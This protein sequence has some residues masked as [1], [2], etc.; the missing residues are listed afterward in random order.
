MES[1]AFRKSG[2]LEVYVVY[3]GKQA[4]KVKLEVSVFDRKQQEFDYLVPNVYQ[5]FSLKKTHSTVIKTYRKRCAIDEH[6]QKFIAKLQCKFVVKLNFEDIVPASVLKTSIGTDLDKLLNSGASHDFMIS[7]TND[8]T[9]PVHKLILS[10]RS[11]VLCA[12]LSSDLVE[13]NKG[14]I[15]IHDFDAAVVKSFVRYLYT[16]RCPES[17]LHDHA[18]ALLQMADKYDVRGLSTKCEIYLAKTLTNE[19]VSDVLNLADYV[20]AHYLME[21][22]AFFVVEN[23]GDILLKCPTFYD[24]IPHSTCKAIAVRLSSCV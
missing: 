8:E 9:L 10:C 6:V 20:H 5:E 11:S 3:H 12:M 16:D 22:G 15:A 19:N 13:S 1:K 23:I 21:M 14:T 17:E 24:T 18:V 2:E 7:L 4:I